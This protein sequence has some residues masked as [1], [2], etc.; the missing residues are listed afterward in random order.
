MEF[1]RLNEFFKIFFLLVF[2]LF[3]SGFSFRNSRFPVVQNLDIKNDVWMVQQTAGLANCTLY[4]KLVES[5][6][7][8]LAKFPTLSVGGNMRKYKE[9][10]LRSSWIYW[11]I[12]IALLD[13]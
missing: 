13:L 4:R 10:N 7:L 2:F 12:S 9:C 6:I 11:K 3:A 8:E 1:S 5:F